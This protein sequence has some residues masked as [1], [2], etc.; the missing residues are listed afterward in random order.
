MN[1][2]LLFWDVPAAIL[3]LVVT[4]LLVQ[5]PI[6]DFG[7]L[8]FGAPVVFVLARRT[9]LPQLSPPDDFEPKPVSWARAIA[10]YSLIIVGGFIAMVAG[11]VVCVG[12]W[13]TPHE[14]IWPALI[15]SGIG[16]LIAIPGVR[17]LTQG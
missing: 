15:V 13:N 9:W 14:F 7:I 8:W 3:G 5:I 2:R 17:W 6:G 16:G 1:L 11:L 4:L 12:A 10:A